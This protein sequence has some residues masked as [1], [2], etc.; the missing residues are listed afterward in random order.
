VVV[1]QKSHLSIVRYW[2][3]SLTEITDEYMRDMLGKS[4]QYSV[5]IL[6]EGLNANKPGVEKIKWEHG[7]RN[8]SLRRNGLLSI[9]CPVSGGGS[10]VGI[11]IFNASVDEVKKIMDEDPAVR[12]DVLRYQVLDCRSF[13]GDCLPK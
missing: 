9:V 3:K 2:W 7:R 4:K 6:T 13:P 12:E 5:I 11:G 1:K 10:I 8:F